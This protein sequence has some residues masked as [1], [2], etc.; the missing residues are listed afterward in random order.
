MGRRKIQFWYT[1]IGIY[2]EWKCSNKLP[3]EKITL[4]VGLGVRPC[5]TNHHTAIKSQCGILGLGQWDQ[6]ENASCSRGEEQFSRAYLSH[7]TTR[8]VSAAEGME[9]CSP[10]FQHYSP[11]FVYGETT[12]S[13]W[14]LIFI[15]SRPFH[16]EDSH[17]CY[18][19]QCI[20]TTLHCSLRPNSIF[21]QQ[22]RFSK[23]PTLT[24]AVLDS[25]ALQETGRVASST[26]MRIRDC[27]Y[28][29]RFISLPNSVAARRRRSA[30]Y[31]K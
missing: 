2:C 16:S 13:R 14:W 31:C 17:S 27:P 23:A 25:L 7:P 22:G 28:C 19:N 3:Y 20:S 26:G 21:R 30:V 9:K 5:S 4:T 11:Q 18:Q 8:F 29:A 12:L 15:S 24:M 1:F 6:W 10:A